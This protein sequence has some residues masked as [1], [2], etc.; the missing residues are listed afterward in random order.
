MVVQEFDVN[1]KWEQIVPG[2]VQRVDMN[3]KQEVWFLCSLDEE[4]SCCFSSCISV[5][6][7]VKI[8]F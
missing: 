4:I 6:L 2:S 5:Q 1:S 8:Y 3:A 7:A